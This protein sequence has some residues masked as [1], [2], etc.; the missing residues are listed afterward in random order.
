MNSTKRKFLLFCLRKKFFNRAF[1]VVGLMLMIT[2]GIIFANSILTLSCNQYGTSD[3][4]LRMLALLVIFSLTAY[5]FF[6][7]IPQK[8]MEKLP[9]WAE[10]EVKK[11]GLATLEFD[12]IFIPLIKEAYKT[13][14]N[15]RLKNAIMI[16]SD[17]I[18]AEKL[19][20]KSLQNLNDM[21]SELGI[22]SDLRRRLTM[23]VL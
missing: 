3:S 10:A 6:S 14:N 4:F 17:T 8:E 19:L 15:I 11:R 9:E 18:E 13:G 16:V 7:L 22:V 20:L 2:T 1:A 21:E 12:P 5:L 23:M